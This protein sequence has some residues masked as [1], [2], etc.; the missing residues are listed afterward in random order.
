VAEVWL[1]NIFR[2]SVIQKY[3]KCVI[4]SIFEC[5]YYIFSIFKEIFLRPTLTVKLIFFQIVETKFDRICVWYNQNDVIRFFNK[6]NHGQ[7][8]ARG[9]HAA[10]SATNAALLQTLKNAILE[11]NRLEFQKKS[12]F[13]PSKLRFFKN[14]ALEPIWVGRGW[15]RVKTNIK[16]Y[17]IWPLLKKRITSFWLYRAHI[18]SIYT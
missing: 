11:Q 7:P 5:S 12:K 3:C 14:V 6:G 13:W 18:L 9:P 1:K 4:I 16:T 17:W 8:A 10:L 15:I 2:S